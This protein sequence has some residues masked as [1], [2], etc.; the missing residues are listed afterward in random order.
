[1]AASEPVAL[2]WGC[3]HIAHYADPERAEVLLS[4]NCPRCAQTK[5]THAQPPPK[6]DLGPMEE[7]ALLR[8]RTPLVSVTF[9]ERWSRYLLREAERRGI[10][11]RELVVELLGI[12]C[13]A[14]QAR[15]PR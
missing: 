13:A 10:S 14:Y 2:P 6:A 8:D 1:M 12:G 7:E 5:G 3:G 11:R 15:T 4:R 9:S